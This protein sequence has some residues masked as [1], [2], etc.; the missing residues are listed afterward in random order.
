MD[1]TG[2]RGNLSLPLQQSR[3]T[4]LPWL[5]VTSQSPISGLLSTPKL[6][7]K[8]AWEVVVLACRLIELTFLTDPAFVDL[9][10]VLGDMTKHTFFGGSPANTLP[11]LPFKLHMVTMVTL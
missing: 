7:G 9:Y 8:I 1:C 6:Q 3:G 2:L 10:S 11:W 4:G 5:L